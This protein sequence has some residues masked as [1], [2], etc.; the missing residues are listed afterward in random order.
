[1]E[2]KLE[3]ANEVHNHVIG[4]TGN[5]DSKASFILAFVGV[6]IPLILTSDYI[7]GSLE[8]LLSEF[9]GYWINE[10]G[11]FSLIALFMFVSLCTTIFFVGKCIVCQISCLTARLNENTASIIFFRSI[12]EQSYE[13][14][15]T[16]VDTKTDDDYLHDKLKQIHICSTICTTK[17]GKYNKGVKAIKIGL[18]FFSLF[19]V[20][21]IIFNA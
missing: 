9:L 16:L 7:I 1:M 13:D 18:L 21:A 19:V 3:Y 14:Y 11:E 2:N 10:K 4:W 6:I 5:C 8:K 17:F 20:F 15:V 12:S